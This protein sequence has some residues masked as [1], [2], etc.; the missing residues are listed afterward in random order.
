MESARRRPLTPRPPTVFPPTVSADALPTWQVNGVVWSQ[1]VVNTVAYVT[2]SFT[3]ARPPGVAAGGAGSVAANNIFA[4]NVTTGNPVASFSHNL[5]G[6]GLV[7]RR[8]PTG[9]KVY[10][11]GDFTTVDGAARGHVAAFNTATGALDATFHPTVSSRVAGP[12]DQQHHRLR[13]RQLLQRGRL[14]PDPAG[15]VRLLD[16]G[17]P[18]VGSQGRRQRGRRPWS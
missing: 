10:V 15:G 2:G 6:Q 8:L 16:R 17:T 14:G 5:N 12:G 1:V 3:Q 13:R 11:G 7:V 4:Y 9:R 18:A